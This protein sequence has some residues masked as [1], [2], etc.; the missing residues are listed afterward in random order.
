MIRCILSSCPGS[1]PQARTPYHHGPH[2]ENN[3]MGRSVSRNAPQCILPPESLYMQ[4]PG[5]F[6]WI[7]H[8]IWVMYKSR[9]D[10]NRAVPGK[11][12]SSPERPAATGTS[13][14]VCLCRL[15]AQRSCA[16]CAHRPSPF[17]TAWI[18]RS[19]Q[20][21]MLRKRRRVMAIQGHP[22]PHPSPRKADR[23]RKRHPIP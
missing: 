21:W 22:T 9:T 1:C 5:V 11:G 4:A 14:P 17:D 8:L 7:K 20:I 15:P 10:P 12:Q 6:L 3:P 23:R 13:S 2:D 18:N 16:S 19:S